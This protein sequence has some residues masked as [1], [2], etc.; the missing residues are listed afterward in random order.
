[1]KHKLIPPAG[2]RPRLPA[3]AKLCL[4]R[5]AGLGVA[6]LAAPA[7]LAQVVVTIEAADDRAAEQPP[8]RAQFVIRRVSGDFFRPVRIPLAV[9]GSATE[10]V[11]Y[12]RLP[13]RVTL[14]F[15]QPAILIDVVPRGNDGLFEGDETVTVM[16]RREDEDDGD[17]ED[18]DDGFIV[19]GSGATVTIA[20][21][22]HTVT[23][24]RRA[25]ALE[26]S[27]PGEIVVSLGA[28]NESGSSLEVSYSV[29]G[30][31]EPGSDYEPL[32]G[33]V[34]IPVGASSASIVVR[35][36]DDDVLENDETVEIT[37]TGTGDGRVSVGNRD[38][39]AIAI[40]DDDASRDDDGDGLSN[41]EECP[42][43]AACRDTDGDALPDFRD[44]DDD[45]DGVPTDAERPP[46]Q[47]TDGDGDP[48]YLDD[49]DDGDG[50]PTRDEDANADGDG[51]PATDPTDLDGDDV[52]DYLDADDGGGVEGDPDGDGLTNG[53]EAEL[54]TDPRNPD[55][56]GD[57]VSDGD[58]EAAG[59]D[60]LDERSFAD[61][62]GDLVPDAVESADGSSP[63]DPVDFRDTDGGGT[64]D[65]VEAV[66][67]PAFGLPATDPGQAGDDHRDVDGDGLPDRLELVLG[68]APGSADSPTANGDGDDD[69]NGVSNA[70][71]AFLAE[72][73]I[74]AAGPASD[75]DR[76]A[77][78]DAAEVV[79]GL[80]PLSSAAPDRDGDGVPNVL[81]ALAGMDVSASTDR[82]GDGVPD[83]REMAL[84]FDP[85]DANSPVAGGAGDDAGDGTTRAIAHVLALLGAGGEPI[86]GGDT[87][88][89]GITDA[90]EIRLGSDPFHHEQ[91]V[92]WTELVQAE[93]GP[94][95]ALAADGGEATARARVG[96]HQSGLV[97][98]WSGT[99]A[100][101]LA[102]TSG[103][104]DAPQLSFAP[105]TLPPGSY[106]LVLAVTRTVGGITS[107]PSVVR[108]PF[109]V[110]AEAPAAT[111]TD[112]D[113]DGVPDP[114]DGSDGRRGP[115][116]EL[117]SEAVAPIVSEPGT[118]LRLGALA[119][120][121]RADS[122]LVS[123]ADIVAAGG[124]EDEYEYIGGLY[125]FEVT[126]LPEAG[127]VVRVVIPQ[128]SPIG[129]AARYR[130]FAAGTG[131]KDFVEDGTDAIASAPGA[132]NECPPPGDAAYQPGLAAGHLCVQ[133]TIADGGRN[134]GDAADGPNGLVK[135]PGGV[136]TPRGEVVVGRGSGST[137]P[138]W[139]LLLAGL[140]AWRLRCRAAAV[141]VLAGACL[142]LPAR[143]DVFVG[144]GAGMSRL[145][146]DTGST[147]FSVS[148]NGG[149]GF[150]VFG[151]FDLA[152]VSPN[153]SLEVFWADLG[154]T[155]LGNV[156]TLDYRAYGAGLVYGIGSVRVPRVSGHVEL[157]VSELD[158]AGDLAFRQ[159]NST[160]LFLGVGGSFAIGRHLFL[161]LEYE[162]F[163]EDAQFISLSFVKRFR[164]FDGSDDARTIPLPDR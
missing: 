26:G 31:A 146:P 80:D 110:L 57:G 114:A 113:Q 61:S 22:A 111:L 105:A 96:G 82:D 152:V 128:A 25:D 76:D 67:Y 33:R 139:L 9:S 107:G 118:R 43:F 11:D 28:R 55:T 157:G 20:D 48:D 160:S 64:P 92:P 98:D 45:G 123:P 151:G 8:D 91:P 73:G 71:Q 144:G 129:N 138:W 70:V 163:A 78:P 12:G 158:I 65:H 97:F 36:L 44:A 108:H 1:M 85:L 21:S 155:K 95:R 117:P 156:G 79:L 24:E 18:D 58:E 103:P 72:R 32:A 132:D 142:A 122:A 137:A 161:Q 74:D 120:A 106:E 101:V 149:F 17:D 104:Q 59:T 63:E 135:D 47:D 38:T 3:R 159:E 15:G 62:D 60:P 119:R 37:L 14:S 102:V 5:L 34:D 124:T 53:R 46:R 10:G 83:V 6:V 133:L 69:G 153:L 30:D 131:W 126:N 147:P 115:A 109:E 68:S 84:G 39:A 143:A 93:L 99:S 23:A 13:D 112:S 94:V 81:E 66:T 52:P 162:Y 42:D 100:A 130:K 4:R 7:A 51:N 136:G 49:D 16:L 40:V 116:H 134:D 56:D 125:D 148:D 90:D 50:R 75:F 77:Y 19:S 29:A 86:A 154:E 164:H 88:G 145:T 87:D 54:G 27:E 150:K 127:G 2:M 41:R 35:P 89:D 141:A 121:V 140:V